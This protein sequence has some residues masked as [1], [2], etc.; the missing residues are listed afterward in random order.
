MLCAPGSGHGKTSITAGL[1]RLYHRKGLR[2]RCFKIGP[3]F[4]DPT[5][6]IKACGSPVYNLDL[7][8]MGVEHCR[9]LLWN[10]AQEADVILVEGAMGLFDGTPSTAD[11]AQIFDL[12]IVPI[13]NAASMAQT[14]AAIVHGVTT[15][16][17]GLTIAGVVANRVASPRHEELLRMEL[18]SSLPLSVVKRCEEATIPE[19]HLGLQ[20][21]NELSDL[22]ARLDHLASLLEE[23]PLAQLP[24]PVEFI[25]P[26][27]VSVNKLSLKNISVAVANDQAFAFL[28]R[29]NL[30][31]LQD[32]GATLHFFSPLNDTVLPKVDAIY[33]PGGYPEL[34]AERLEKN[35]QLA[36]QIRVHVRAAKPLLAECGGML[37]LADSL[38]DLNDKK[39]SMLGSLPGEIHMNKRLTALGPQQLEMQNTVVRGH[40]FHYSSFKTEL[41]PCWTAVTPDGR[42]G[43][44]VYRHGSIV[45][46][47]V[48]WYFPSNPALI[49]NWL[50]GENAESSTT[51]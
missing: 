12:P 21:G 45:A 14:F 2:V 25:P 27:S 10:A 7:W 4:I 43:E 46:S 19:R 30:E 18:P 50:R 9:S 17:A 1:A 33:L 13:I 11:V 29:S 34:H 35:D 42:T 8:M 20:L 23:T 24:A 49:E 26:T 40:T 44:A 37:Y 22:D 5:I 32:L 16:R 41:E 51:S 36:E 6:L 28:Y 39:Y 31:W 38:T 47:Y 3:D 48:H 15:F